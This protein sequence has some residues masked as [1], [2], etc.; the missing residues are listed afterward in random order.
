M[1]QSLKNVFVCK[2]TTSKL[3]MM[4]KLLKLKF[5]GVETLLR[6]LEALEATLDK[7][8]K[9]CYLILMMTEKLNNVVTAIETMISN[10]TLEFVT[11]RLLDAEFCMLDGQSHD[12][13]DPAVGY[14]K[15]ILLLDLS[16]MIKKWWLLQQL[17]Y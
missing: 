8:D 14:I 13:V 3:F 12:V 17:L 4:K 15:I 9:V 16:V 11:G 6:Q 7:T 10:I 2:S 1:M 5:Q